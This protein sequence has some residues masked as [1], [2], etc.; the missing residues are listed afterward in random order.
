VLI[1]TIAGQLSKALKSVKRFGT[2]FL[3]IH[4]ATP[5]LTGCGKKDR[6]SDQS[7]FGLSNQN[8]L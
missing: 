2:T 7:L 1:T 4:V 6:N 3:H 5:I 8:C